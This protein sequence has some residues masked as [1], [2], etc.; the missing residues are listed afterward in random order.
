MTN[1]KNN[2]IITITLPLNVYEALKVLAEEDMRSARMYISRVLIDHVPEEM[3]GKKLSPLKT[4]TKP[5]GSSA[6]SP[7]KQ[8][9]FC[10]KCQETVDHRFSS[11]LCKQ[12][13]G[14]K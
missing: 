11:T 9:T 5:T 13:A 3:L 2:T 4:Q 1:T 8:M 14:F 6:A 10:V 12:C 7:Q